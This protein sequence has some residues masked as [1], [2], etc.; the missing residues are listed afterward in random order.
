MRTKIQ[1][2][3]LTI[4]LVFLLGHASTSPAA[5]RLELLGHG[6]GDVF[7][8]V[9]YLSMS[10]DGNTLAL[11]YGCGPLSDCASTFAIVDL[12][13]MRPVG[14]STENI[15]VDGYAL[16]PTGQF[17]GGFGYTHRAVER[18]PTIW[19]EESGPRIL[20]DATG[21][22]RENMLLDISVNGRTAVGIAHERPFVWSNGEVKQ[23]N[24]LSPTR[25]GRVIAVSNDGQHVAGTSRN[26]AFYWEIGAGDYIPLE[27]IAG[28]SYSS[29]SDIS[30]DGQFAVGVSSGG[31]DSSAFRWSRETGTQAIGDFTPVAI[32]GNG[33]IVVGNSRTANR[34]PVIWRSGTGLQ[35]IAEYIQDVHQID[36]N[37][38]GWIFNDATGVSDDGLVLMGRGYF[39]DRWSTWMLRVGDFDACDL[40]ADGACDVI[41]IDALTTTSRNRIIRSSFDLN[42]DFQIDS[43][44]HTIWIADLMQTY[45]GDANLDGEFD[46]SDLTLVFQA[47]KYETDE[48]A[49]WSEGDWNGDG[50]A[51]ASDMILA[52]TQAA[53]EQGPRPVQSVPEPS[54]AVSVTV[55][56]ATLRAFK[57][58]PRMKT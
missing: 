13:T 46:S 38:T 12:K 2:S 8:S 4:L 57:R 23:P 24:G 20:T 3:R 36:A 48:S 28:H 19:S 56:I 15:T 21:S 55:A 43:N 52:F 14:I 42:R 5:G 39:E 6:G 25:T 30:A 32:S 45:H 40:N 18:G 1:H 54:S 9:D 33:G 7:F 26:Q 17:A 41:D 44:D 50:F 34:Q 29:V 53:Y 49:S 37:A 16:S 22:S 11:A 58:K 10:G 47:T 31:A 27:T 35:T 51:N